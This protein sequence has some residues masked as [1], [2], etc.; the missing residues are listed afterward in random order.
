LVI[1]VVGEVKS[2]I[3]IVVSDIVVNHD[4][5]F[6]GIE[7]RVGDDGSKGRTADHVVAIHVAAEG[8]VVEVVG[9]SVVVN[10]SDVMRDMNMTVIVVVVRVYVGVVGSRAVIRAVT[11]R[12]SARV[13]AVVASVVAS[14]LSSRTGLVTTVVVASVA[15]T[16]DRLR[17]CRTLFC[18][19]TSFCRH[20]RSSTIGSSCFDLT[21][22]GGRSCR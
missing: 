13:S 19:T 3:I 11:I 6:P 9:N 12:V 1:I 22:I 8:A 5:G 10:R 14:G 16:A 2:A 21:C 17:L 15:G 7:D 20:I 18:V 4:Y